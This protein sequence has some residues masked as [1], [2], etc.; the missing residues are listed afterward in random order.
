M[1]KTITADVVQAVGDLTVVI[2]DAVA[3][4]DR[5]RALPSSMIA[6]LRDLDA[7]RLLAPRDVRGA[8][9]DPLTFVRVAEAAAR[10]DG[11]TGWCLMIA[12]C[13]AAF[14]GLLPEGGARTI[15]GDESTIVAGAFRPFG[16]AVEVDGGYRVSGQWPLASGS[17]FATGYVGGCVVM[18]DGEPVIGPAGTPVMREA[19][20]RAEHVEVIDTW[21][22]TG[23]RATASH[24]F[25]VSDVFVPADHTM[26]FGE[27]PRRPH[28][29]RRR[30]CAVRL[31]RGDGRLPH[32][33]AR[34]VPARRPHRRPARLYAGAELRARRAP[35]PRPVRRAEPVDDGSARLG[36]NQRPTYCGARFSRND[37]TPSR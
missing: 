7:F 9:L 24:D 37:L 10:A 11:S 13:F 33:P 15:F 32:L 8:E 14:G 4:A 28:R 19:A 31:G 21:G 26:W 12:N 3:D 2:R 1:P 20:F 27:H 16:R 17:T 22:S 18:A 34:A 36:L 35:A 6:A 23:L 30:R 25:A 29:R 5:T